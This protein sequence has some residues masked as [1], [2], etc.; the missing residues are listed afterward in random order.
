LRFLNAY[1]RTN[2]KKKTE[3]KFSILSEKIKNKN[4]LSFIIE[5]TLQ[6]FLEL[7]I[8]LAAVFFYRTASEYGF[9]AKK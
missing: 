2:S 3:K 1:Y 4:H 5:C 7:V 9:A 6:Y 8:L